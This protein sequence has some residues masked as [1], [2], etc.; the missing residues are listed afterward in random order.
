LGTGGVSL[1][2][3]PPE[4]DP[5]RV[6]VVV[7]AFGAGADAPGP[8]YISTPSVSASRSG[9]SEQPHRAVN[10][11]SVRRAAFVPNRRFTGA[12]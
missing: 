3:L 11:K 7:F 1:V 12:V 6:G 8:A 9:A 10:G 5:E 2:E 4:G